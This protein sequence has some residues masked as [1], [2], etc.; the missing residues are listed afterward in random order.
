MASYTELLQSLERLPDS[1][2]KAHIPSDWMQGRTTY[3]GLSAA[4]CLEAAQ[5]LL[6]TSEKP[7]RT[8]QMAFV[9]PVSGDV[10]VHAQVLRAGKNTAFVRAEIMAEGAISTQA[11]FTFGKGRDSQLH[12]SAVAMPDV[13]A[14]ETFPD[15]FRSGAGPSFARHFDVRLAYGSP[16]VSNTE[17]NEIGLWMRHADPAAPS[18]ATA[19]LALG[20]APPPAA[21]SMLKTHGPV[22]SMTWYL[23][24]LTTDLQ[25]EARWFFARHTA[26]TAMQGYSSQSMTLWNRSGRPIV[27]ARQMIAVFG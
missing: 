16:P 1:T 24:F 7:I 12:H 22:S 11:I 4:L 26:D 27:R 8:A 20:D 9:G 19:L 23:D 14:P 15:F 5:S 10:S 25:T 3:G 2:V 18:D 17:D 21:L 13:A 6:D